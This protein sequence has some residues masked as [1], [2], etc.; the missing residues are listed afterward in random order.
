VGRGWRAVATYLSLAPGTHVLLLVVSVT[1]LMQRGLDATTDTRVLRESST[2]LV[3]MSRAAPRVLFLSAFLLDHGHLLVELVLF[4]IVMVPVERWIGTYRWIG[5]F[6]AGHV[7]AT[8]ATTIGIWLQVR[9]GAT[10]RSLVYPLDVGVSYGLV[11]VA[12]VLSRRLPRPLGA[13]VTVAL[14]ARLGFA[15]V[16][17]GT[18]TDWG[19][20]AA[21]AIGLALAPLV[22][23]TG[24]RLAVAHD[25]SSP[26]LVQVWRWLSTPPPLPSRPHTTIVMRAIGWVLLTVAFGLVVVLAV[27]GDTGVAVPGPETTLHAHVL[28]PTAACG[29]NCRSAVVG[30]LLGGIAERATVNLPRGL[31]LHAGDSVDVVID[32]ATGSQPRLPTTAR[33]VNA[34]GFLGALAAISAL[35]GAA[36]VALGGRH[37]RVEARNIAQ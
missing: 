36:V 19:H 2:N 25:P 24:T 31:A 20:L 18:F 22:R 12:A 14:G 9:S 15:I 7:G 34:S 23:P 27:T 21:F 29:S 10:Q 13:F 11:A 30:Y 37:R 16:Y 28:G 1:T 26:V 32:P 17:G 6:A 35:V 33:R 5:V 4:T 8:L 3:L